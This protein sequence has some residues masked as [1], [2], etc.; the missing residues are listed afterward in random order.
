MYIICNLFILN[1]KL[2]KKIKLK[3]RYFNKV[4]LYEIINQ[5]IILLL[6]K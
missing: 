3:F 4:I 6:Q 5:N 2:K 1:I